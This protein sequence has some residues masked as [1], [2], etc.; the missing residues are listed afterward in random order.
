LGIGSWF[1]VLG[2]GMFA[3]E[4]VECSLKLLRCNLF[5]ATPQRRHAFCSVFVFD[6]LFAGE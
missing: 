4:I 2:A 1:L 3:A 5:H 6:V